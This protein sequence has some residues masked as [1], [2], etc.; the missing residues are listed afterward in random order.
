VLAASGRRPVDAIPLKVAASVTHLGL[1]ARLIA[2]ALAAAAC[3]HDLDMGPDELWWQDTIAGPVPLSVTRGR[4]L[5]QRAGQRC[6][7]PGS[8]QILDELICPITAA[9]QTA[10]SPRVLWGNVASAINS[11]ASQA[12]GH[13]PALG[14]AAWAVAR[15][16]LGHP[17]LSQE[18]AMPGPAFRRSS[19]CLIYKLTPGPPQPVCADCLLRLPGHGVAYLAGGRDQV[20]QGW[21]GLGVTAGLQAAVGVDP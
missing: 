4:R 17:Q 20:A 11:A 15:A 9:G 8:R 19:C 12:A 1:V 3:R 2:P 16:Y 10:V 21:F 6:G 13:R 18:P 7:P 14:P 5:G